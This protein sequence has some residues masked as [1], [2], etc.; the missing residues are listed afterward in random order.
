MSIET[1]LELSDD[2]EL[3]LAAEALLDAAMSYWQAYSRATGGAAVVWVKDT[4]GRMVIITR[5]E[6]QQTLMANIDV[7]RRHEE[8]IVP[9]DED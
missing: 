4:D 6:Y 5:G 1:N 8:L 7:L 3:R 2:S 9:Y